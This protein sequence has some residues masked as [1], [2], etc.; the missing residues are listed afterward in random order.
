MVADG[1]D[2]LERGGGFGLLGEGELVH[3]LEVEGDLV[4][5]R[6]GQFVQLLHERRFGRRLDHE[7]ELLLFPC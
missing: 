4:E 2:A 5:E 6:A 1:E 3:E 7:I